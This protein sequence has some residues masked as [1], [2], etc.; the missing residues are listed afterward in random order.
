[1]QR[2]YVTT[3][4]SGWM[5][6]QFPRKRISS[7]NPLLCLFIA[8]HYVI[9]LW[10]LWDI[11]LVTSSHNYLHSPNLLA[12]KAEWETEKS[13]T[14]L[15]YQQ[16]FGDRPPSQKEA[17]HSPNHFFPSFIALST[18]LWHL[19]WVHSSWRALFLCHLYIYSY[20]F[21]F[22]QKQ[23]HAP[24]LILHS[25]EHILCLVLHALFCFCLFFRLIAKL[26]FS[27]WVSFRILLAQRKQKYYYT[28]FS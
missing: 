8:W 6:S 14:S 21:I 11:S 18:F 3:P 10:L 9:S 23:G 5:P 13:L 28:A 20:A 4:A 12:S 1:M 26:Y 25:T 24:F 2:Q 15:C 16:S 22:S 19:F 27:L 7:T 17:V